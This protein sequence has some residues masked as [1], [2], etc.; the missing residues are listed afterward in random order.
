MV[1]YLLQI[2]AM[3]TFEIHLL[4]MEGRRLKVLGLIVHG[5]RL[6]NDWGVLIVTIHVLTGYALVAYQITWS[7]F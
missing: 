7:L 4:E 5:T 2:G 3:L 6:G 1:A